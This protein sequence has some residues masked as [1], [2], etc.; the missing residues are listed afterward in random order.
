M[1]QVIGQTEL[2]SKMHLIFGEPL[3]TISLVKAP[4]AMH[5]RVHA[6]RAPH[7][8][9]GRGHQEGRRGRHAQQKPR[10]DGHP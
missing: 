6:L 8:V 7:H 10:Q 3:V 4:G 1:A 2:N 5:R 9:L